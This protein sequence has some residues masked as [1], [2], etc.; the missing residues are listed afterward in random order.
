MIDQGWLTDSNTQRLTKP[1]LSLP[2]GFFRK[3]PE[4]TQAQRKSEARQAFVIGVASCVGARVVTTVCKSVQYVFGTGTVGSPGSFL[5]LFSLFP[6]TERG[7]A[8]EAAH[9]FV[10]TVPYYV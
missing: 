3:R 7:P 4:E 10:Q 2:L 5:L 9:L 8:A 6:H 1:A